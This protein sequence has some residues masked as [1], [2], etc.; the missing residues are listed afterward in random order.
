MEWWH[1]ISIMQLLIKIKKST[2]LIYYFPSNLVL[3]TLDTKRLRTW[4]IDGNPLRL[5]EALLTPTSQTQIAALT[6]RN[7]TLLCTTSYWQTSLDSGLLALAPPAAVLSV[8]YEATVLVQPLRNH[9][10]ISCL[11]GSKSTSLHCSTLVQCVTFVW[12]TNIV[13]KNLPTNCKSRE[14]ADLQSSPQ[15]P[16]GFNHCQS[17]S[18]MHFGRPGRTRVTAL[19]CTASYL[20]SAQEY[21]NNK[22]A[23]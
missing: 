6:L 18:L 16:C 1:E 17:S 19:S 4:K 22:H 9:C 10:V 12:Q 13:F 8:F 21:K 2:L 20:C 11:T 15:A 23:L 5:L 7:I 14:T 3:Q